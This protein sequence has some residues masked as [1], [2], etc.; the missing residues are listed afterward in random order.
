MNNTNEVVEDLFSKSFRQLMSMGMPYPVKLIMWWARDSSQTLVCND[1]FSSSQIYSGDIEDFNPEIKNRFEMLLD[2]LTLS[3]VVK[4]YDSSSNLFAMMYVNFYQ[5]DGIEWSWIIN[6]L[7]KLGATEE[8][9]PLLIRFGK[10]RRQMHINSFTTKEKWLNAPIELAI[11]HFSLTKC[12]ESKKTRNTKVVDLL[13]FEPPADGFRLREAQKAV[14]RLF[15]IGFETEDGPFMKGM[16]SL[17][18][19]TGDFMQTN[20]TPEEIITFFKKNKHKL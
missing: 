5:L 20:P 14:Q 3:K 16:S 4:D 11:P 6:T 13:S 9:C 7:C 15:E 19:E 17:N 8:D 12:Y 2:V 18:E 1:M 10:R